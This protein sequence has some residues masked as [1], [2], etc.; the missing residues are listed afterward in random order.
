M[1]EEGGEQPMSLDQEA[2]KNAVPSSSDSE[3]SDNDEAG[4]PPVEW[5]ATTRAKR[6]TAGNRMKSMLAAEE[7][8]DE[9]ELLFAEDADDAGFTDVGEGDSD[10]QM[11][12]SSD[13]EDAQNQG[14]DEAGEKELEKQA[15]E[16][17]LATRKRKAQEAIPVKFRKKVRADPTATSSSTA[18]PA[19]RPKKKSERA[20][21]LPSLAD[22]PTRASKRETTMLSKEALHQQMVERE[23]KRLKL[24][25]AMERKAKRMEALKKPPMTQAE[26]MAEAAKVEKR[27][28][29]SLNRWEE[30]EKQ[31]EE[32]RKAKLA[33]LN[34]RQ[35]SGPVVTFWSGM[36]E[37]VDGKLKHL[38]KS[39]T[40]EERPAKK[41]LSTVGAEKLAD[42]PVQE[43][44]AQNEQ[45]KV[46]KP[47]ADTI[48]APVASDKAAVLPAG[49]PHTTGTGT[50][51]KSANIEKS[52]SVTTP[53]LHTM[54]SKQQD[55]IGPSMAVPEEQIAQ[56]P[57]TTESKAPDTKVLEPTIQEPPPRPAPP[58]T[59]P[60]ETRPTQ[61]TPSS[62]KPAEMRPPDLQP[63][64]SGP[65]TTSMF[66][67][68]LQ[69]QG[70]VM[71]PPE[72]RPPTNS[73][74]APPSGTS[75]LSMPVLGYSPHPP[76][77][78][79]P[80]NG[81][82]APN[83]GQRQ[84]PLSMPQTNARPPPPPPATARARPPTPSQQSPIAPPSMVPVAKPQQSLTQPAPK[85]LGILKP[86][87]TN[88]SKKAKEQPGLPDL[89]PSP[90]SPPPPNMKA[91][92]NSIIL[93]NFDENAIEQKSVQ[94]RI[95]FG[96]ETG[97]LAKPAPPPKCIITNKPARYKD[98]KTGLPYY[99]SKAYK[100]IQKLQRGDYKWSQLVG[101][102]VGT[103]SFAAQGVP[104][105]FLDPD[106]PA[107]PKP[108]S[109]V[110][111]EPSA[112]P[113]PAQAAV[114]DP[115]AAATTPSTQGQQMPPTPVAASPSPGS[116]NAAATFPRP[117]SAAPV[118]A[119]SAPTLAVAGNSTLATPASPLPTA[120][121]APTPP[122]NP[123]PMIQ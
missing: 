43:E 116:V 75:G 1:A 84:S 8:D 119:Q 60:S 6:S 31:R 115:P 100:E 99:D 7:P 45:S 56:P 82:A 40:I 28:A 9:L 68:P 71:K 20:S 51:P 46:S 39:V 108:A 81:L 78:N 55:L 50:S 35:L 86:S 94:Q 26:R 61:T 70:P 123:A 59:T 67:P 66:A 23:A 73:F 62:S 96:K 10:V 91:T 90:R 38:G 25:E 110:K 92:R 27:N 80:S 114:A 102:W 109:P 14:D 54:D 104:A 121:A 105:R 72:M 24:M 57:P 37:W 118:S 34:N 19:P 74:L 79:Q 65:Y 77:T 111:Q 107:P 64:S 101:A 11:D 5:L 120:A 30:A 16:R 83:A 53:Q 22:L 4:P 52:V 112:T 76:P 117:P 13:E 33:A 87:H 106:A 85:P 41:R 93:Q 15:R 32:E 49:D 3:S 2:E 47:P 58:Q 12:S 122:A 98:P 21:W 97:K 36:G 95:L 69:A 42:V 18:T 44:P 89:P 29:K 88:A 63:P 17:K 48:S 103:G 113:E